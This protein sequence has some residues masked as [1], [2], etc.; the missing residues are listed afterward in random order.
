M[1]NPTTNVRA[2]SVNN[3]IYLLGRLVNIAEHAQHSEVCYVVGG[4][5]G[6]TR[7]TYEETIYVFEEEKWKQVASMTVP[8]ANHAVS[9]ISL[10]QE[11]IDKYC[12]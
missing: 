7:K 8:R 9:G 6:E 12:I 5:T 10:L 3:K 11:N 4:E 2:V 1:P